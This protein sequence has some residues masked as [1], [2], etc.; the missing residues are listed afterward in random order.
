MMYEKPI[1]ELIELEVDDIVCTSP[2][3]EEGLGGG[4]GG[5]NDNPWG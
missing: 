1:A 5:D 4:N 2:D 3:D